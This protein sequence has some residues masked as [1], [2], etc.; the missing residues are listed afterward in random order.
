M[1][2][3]VVISRLDGLDPGSRS[4]KA[5]PLERVLGVFGDSLSGLMYRVSSVSS[6]GRIDVNSTGRRVVVP[7][8]PV[9][10]LVTFVV[11]VAAAGAGA[12][13]VA[14]AVVAAFAA[15]AADDSKT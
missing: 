6:N 10:V 8:V 15:T 2:L 9:V 3:G 4:G 11:V 12:V 1:I 7:V 14:G 13:V 5:E